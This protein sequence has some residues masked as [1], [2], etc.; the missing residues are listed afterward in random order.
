MNIS[1]VTSIR[2]IEKNTHDYT[3]NSNQ[4]GN[5]KIQK[6]Q[7][8]NLEQM[9]SDWGQGKIGLSE[10]RKYKQE[11][12][13]IKNKADETNNSYNIWTNTIRQLYAYLDVIKA[14]MHEI[15]EETDSTGTSQNKL[16][17]FFSAFKNKV[18]QT[19]ANADGLKNS[20]GKIPNITNKITNNI[21]GIGKGIKNGIGHVL[22]YA[23]AL[24]SLRGIY[25][26]LSSCA[27]SWL[28]SQNA[29]AKQLSANIDYMKYAMGSAL[30]P[31]IQFVTNLVYQLMKAIQSVAYALTGVNI[32]AKASAKSYSSMAGSANKAKEATKQ[33]AGIHNEINN[34]NKNNS[35]EGG[36]GGGSAP[37]F[38]LS[39]VD[40]TNSIADAI[41][42]GNWYEIGSIIGTKLNEALESIPWDK[43]QNT[44]RKIGTNI[45]QFLNGFIATTNWHEVGNTLAQG[46]NTVIYFG[47]NFIKTFD[48]K[49]FGT[50]ISESIN[51]FFKNVDWT[52]LAQTFSEGVAGLID[53]V[54]GF[55]TNLDWEAIIDAIIKCFNGLDFERI[56]SSLS[57][58]LGATAGSLVKLGIVIGQKINEAIDSAKEYFKSKVEECGGYIVAGIHK[59]INDAIKGIGKWIYDNIFKPFIEG[60]KKAFEINSPSKVMEEQGN[61]IVEG[62]KKGISNI[63]ES[64]K[65]IFINLVKNISDKFTEMK[66]NIS[67]WS[68]DVKTKW[69]EHW[70][71]MK[72]KTENSLN[73]AKSTINTWG[74]NIKT[75]FTNLGKSA[76]TWGKD[77]VSNMAS[78]IQNNIGKVTNAVNKVASK[79]KS[80]LGFSEPE[81]GPLSNFH[82]YMPDMIDL[83]AK[84]IRE[85]MSTVTKELDNL[86]GTM[87]YKINTD[88]I[89]DFKDIS[90]NKK[91]NTDKIRTQ[92]TLRETLRDLISENMWNSNKSSNEEELKKIVIQFGSIEVAMEIEELLRQAKRQNGTATVEI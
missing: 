9:Y 31:V 14:K 38:D 50:S 19:K 91:M 66:N 60:F 74:D 73:S 49:K 71:D 37:S 81:E 8:S 5:A 30:A 33:L 47:Y 61:F 80:L 10:I 28:S 17:S 83:M 51:G 21:K 45:A 1:G 26:I 57:E 88:T 29:G 70:D 65:T 87:S 40:M 72:D 79:I 77:V 53:T 92:N 44:A 86:T 16:T 78:G 64:V 43:I 46:I 6:T 56:W 85:N 82:T 84:G 18:A 3:R 35:N 48:W 4:D 68:T 2:G 59:G 89:P 90:I 52:V 55:I 36:S 23:M 39:K 54:T 63:W 27:N 75:T 7:T 13:E 22:K 76:T 11:Q 25:S 69:G 32:F 15:K 12:N 41:K 58:M 20:F 62:F 42:N 24:F 67:S 34:I